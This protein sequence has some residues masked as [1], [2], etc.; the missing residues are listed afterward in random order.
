MATDAIYEE[1]GSDWLHQVSVVATTRWLQRDQTLPLLVKGVACETTCGSG[2]Q[3]VTVKNCQKITLFGI[4][5]LYN[6]PS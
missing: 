1:H 2:L 3:V 5:F 4:P 6:L